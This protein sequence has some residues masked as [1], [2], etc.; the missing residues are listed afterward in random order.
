MN[1]GQIAWNPLLERLHK[2][3]DREQERIDETLR[4]LDALR[5]AVVKR[6]ESALRALMQQIDRQQ[7]QVR[8][9]EQQRRQLQAELAEAT[10]CPPEEMNLSHLCTVVG[11][12]DCAKI[13]A[14]QRDLQQHVRHL[15]SEH[16][17]TTMLLRDCARINQGLL[18]C[19][20]GDVATPTYDARGQSAWRVETPVVSMQA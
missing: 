9:H 17:L 18:R 6:D 20:L 1:T 13:R 16:R 19:L 7:H 14:R 8:R 2:L 15:R 5:A 3:L 12:A 11:P 4:Q 10:G